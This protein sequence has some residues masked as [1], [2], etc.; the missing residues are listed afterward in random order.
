MLYTY[1]GEVYILSNG[2]FT[3][4]RLEGDNL[5]PTDEIIYDLPKEKDLITATEAKKIL[6]G[7]NFTSSGST[8]SRNSG[9]E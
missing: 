8:R 5:V 2:K 9:R 3:K 4:L 6:N 1:Q 7:S